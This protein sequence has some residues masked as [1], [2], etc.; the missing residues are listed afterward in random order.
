MLEYSKTQIKMNQERVRLIVQ[1]MELLVR[2][3]KDELNPQSLELEL[4]KYDD[5]DEIFDE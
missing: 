3:L 1:N 5:Y 4:P 2:A